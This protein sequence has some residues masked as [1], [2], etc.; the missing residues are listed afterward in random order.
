MGQKH[1]ISEKWVAATTP[2][3]DAQFGQ[4]TWRISAARSSKLDGALIW[5]AH[6]APNKDKKSTWL[7]KK[8]IETM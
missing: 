2:L 3:G 5:L 7:L 6:R 1:I 4:S 8:K